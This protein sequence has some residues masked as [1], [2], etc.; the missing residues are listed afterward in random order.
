[1]AVLEATAP[2]EQFYVTA[3]FW[4]RFSVLLSIALS[5]A[6]LTLSALASLKTQ[7]PDKLKVLTVSGVVVNSISIM[8]SA[9]TSLDWQS[10]ETQD[11][12]F[13]QQLCG[14]M[15]LHEGG[16]GRVVIPEKMD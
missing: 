2:S 12:A 1:M 16:S 8:L 15:H 7:S 13:A 6:S 10:K 4:K 11:K 5:V 3:K 9:L 14:V